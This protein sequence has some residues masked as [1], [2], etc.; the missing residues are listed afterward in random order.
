M[1][2]KCTK[3]PFKKT[4]DCTQSFIRKYHNSCTTYN[5]DSKNESINEDIDNFLASNGFV[6]EKPKKTKSQPKT[7]KK[8]TKTN[9]TKK[10]SHGKS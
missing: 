2:T 8:N 4:K 1:G 7:V 9:G 6:K 3:C 5:I 10:V